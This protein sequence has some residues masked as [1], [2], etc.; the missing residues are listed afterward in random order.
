MRHSVISKTLV[1]S[2]AIGSQ[3][4]YS[5]LVERD[6]ASE[7]WDDIKEAATCAGCQVYVAWPMSYGDG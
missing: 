6:L 7:I 2:L 5:G 4:S 3:A 1:S